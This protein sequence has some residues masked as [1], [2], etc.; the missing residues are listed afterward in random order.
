MMGTDSSSNILI[1]QKQGNST[2]NTQTVYK[3]NP[4]RTELLSVA[5]TRTTTLQDENQQTRGFMVS[6]TFDDGKGAQ[7]ISTI[8]TPERRIARQTEIT[9][10]KTISIQ[11]GHSGTDHGFP[12]VWSAILSPGIRPA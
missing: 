6:M 11:A 9:A 12:F 5:T 1:G 8:L 3:Y 7:N 10:D 4:T 2:D